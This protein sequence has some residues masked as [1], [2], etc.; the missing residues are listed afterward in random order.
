MASPSPARM[1]KHCLSTSSLQEPFFTLFTNVPWVS[2]TENCE[3]GE[4]NPRPL[5]G[6]NAAA[7]GLW[8][9]GSKDTNLFCPLV[10]N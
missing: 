5:S 3:V 2:T 8:E 1:L 9:V 7:N 6:D 10:H 4:K